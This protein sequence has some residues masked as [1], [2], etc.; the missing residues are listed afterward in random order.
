MK[1]TLNAIIAFF[2]VMP[3]LLISYQLG[4]SSLTKTDLKNYLDQ[5][6]LRTSLTAIAKTSLPKKPSLPEKRPGGG[7]LAIEAAVVLAWDFK[8]DFY[9]TT[10]NIDQARPLASLTKLITAAVVLDYASPNETVTVSKTAIENEGDQGGLIT[11]ETLTVRDLLAA[12]LLESSN[13]AAYSLAEYVG[14]KLETNKD[15]PAGPV[16]VFVKLMNEKFNN[17]G[18]TS[19][20]F[21]DP[22]GLEDIKSFSTAKDFSQFI[23]HLRASARYTEIWNLL[24]I[25][26]YQAAALNGLAI[27]YFKNTNPFFGEFSGIIGGK[28]GYT[29]NALGNMLLILADPDGSEILYLVLGSMDRFEEMKQLVNWT[30]A[31]WVWPTK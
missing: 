19:S 27:H 10:K 11:G 2:V 26:D 17:L 5:P 30:G 13:D 3:L 15:Y 14:A 9:L 6:A 31:S 24:K 16:R 21:A 23:K 8:R 12:A 28:T 18:L 4:T 1:S 29:E 22:A 25:T 7:D 20:N